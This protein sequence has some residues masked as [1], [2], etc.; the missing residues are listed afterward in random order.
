MVVFMNFKRVQRATYVK[1]VNADSH[2]RFA[3]RHILNA[4]SWKQSI[5][6]SYLQSVKIK[7]HPL[8]AFFCQVKNTL[9]FIFL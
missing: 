6:I 7:A 9:L 5:K 3:K 2:G 4:F 1:M 8:D